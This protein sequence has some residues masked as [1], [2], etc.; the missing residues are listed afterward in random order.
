MGEAIEVFV[1]AAA[2]RFRSYV[3]RLAEGEATPI[4]ASRCVII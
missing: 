3:E 1:G 2:E 4:G